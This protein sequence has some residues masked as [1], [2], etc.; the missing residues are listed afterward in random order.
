MSRNLVV[1]LDGT[2][3]QLRAKGNT[4]VVLL[5]ELLDHSDPIKQ[6]AYY[7]PGVGTF[8]SAG[9]WT[10]LARAISRLGGLAFGWG[11][12]QNLGEAYTWLMQNWAPGDQVFVFGFSRGAYTARSLVGILRAIGVLR[13]GSENL[14]PYVVAAYARRAGETTIDWDEVHLTSEVFAQ[15]VDGK[16]TIPVKYLGLW[17]TVKA[18][19][20]LRWEVTWPFTRELPNAARIRHA[21]SINEQRAPFKEYLVDAR[22]DGTLEEVWFAG[23]HSDVGGTF[24]DDPPPGQITRPGKNTHA[25]RLSRITLKWIIEGAIA[26][27]LLVRSRAPIAACTVTPADATSKLHR[28]GRAWALLG[29]RDRKIPAGASVHASV[30]TRALT[31]PTFKA[32][33]NVLWADPDWVGQPRLPAPAGTDQ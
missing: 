5:Y 24:V 16:S 1:C 8:S 33:T 10:P 7:D 13:P 27:G 12:R 15:H 22:T 28:R 11:L 4:N 17:D 26:E 14:V 18:A 6:I 31:D 20:F 30:N 29:T 32:P 3:A 21:V 9:A 23:V 2:G 19:G 25:P